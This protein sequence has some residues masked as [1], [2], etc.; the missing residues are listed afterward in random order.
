MS[1][2]G[3]AVFARMTAIIAADY[4]KGHNTHGSAGLVNNFQTIL[5][6]WNQ[7]LLVHIAPGCASKREALWPIQNH[8][9]ALC[10]VM[11]CK[12]N[13]AKQWLHLNQQPVTA[14]LTDP[15]TTN[16]L[17]RT[18]RSRVT[19]ITHVVYFTDLRAEQNKQRNV[20]AWNNNFVETRFSADSKREPVFW[21][22]A[23]R[24]QKSWFQHR[25]VS[26][27]PQT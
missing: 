4:R 8:R 1:L 3:Y 7:G 25:P 12:A 24:Q 14:T 15:I 11:Y 9:S 5:E 19:S 16:R 26:E 21:L 22:P 13:S 27:E 10:V 17:Q 6:R 2:T 18:P 20:R 23:S